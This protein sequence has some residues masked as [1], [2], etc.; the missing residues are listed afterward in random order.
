MLFNSLA[1]FLFFPIVTAIYFALPHRWRWL[2]LLLASCYF[3]MF[4]VP[5]YVLILAGTIVID[6]FAGILISGAEGRR[7]RLYLMA[8]LAANLG[9]LAFFKYYNF[10][11]ATLLQLTGAVGAEWPLP[12]LGILLPIGLSFHTFQAMS[13]TIEVYRGH[14]APE[15]HFGI[16]ALYVM[17]YPQLVAGPI[18]RPQHLLP[19]FH[20][21]HHF[22]SVNARAGLQ[23]MLLGLCKKVV[24]ADTVAPVVNAVYAAP[25]NH[26]AL[27]LAGATALFA[28][29]IYAD[30][31]GYSDI[32]RG[33]AR[34]MGFDLMVNFNRPYLARSVSEF[35]KRWHISL[36]TWFRDYVYVSLGGNRVSYPR[37]QANLLLTFLLSGL[38]HGASWTFVIW[39]GINGLY[40]VTSNWTA[41]A[42]IRLVRWLRLDRVPVIHA[43]M[44]VTFV[45][46][47]VCVA[48]VFFRASSIH[49]ART[50]LST[51]ASGDGLNPRAALM[52]LSAA[53]L[54]LPT[55]MLAAA[56]A[57]G[58]L[59]FDFAVE[60]RLSPDWF[61]RRPI[62][63]RWGA[64]YAGIALILALL[65]EQQFIYFQF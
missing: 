17:F 18:E 49:D 65:G 58:L 33:A 51:M 45:F 1:F 34:V 22:S 40:L 50:I 48:W 15:R 20:Q 9:V 11:N 26:G 64:Y 61:D 27:A 10:L 5:V 43:S 35:W 21:P 30:F 25:G 7:R 8:S 44:Q 32:A 36:S 4:F 16:Y 29:Q 31:S 53:G 56:L 63:V 47:I 24:V 28:V 42:R 19:Q 2:H 60:H 55:L 12:F 14:Q 6:Y 62:W 57:A 59:L 13:Y 41:G 54:Q 39:G 3:Y 37:W 23:L 38:W 46:L 52:S